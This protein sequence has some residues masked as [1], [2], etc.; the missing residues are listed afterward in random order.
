MFGLDV[1]PEIMLQYALPAAGAVFIFAIGIL[2][3]KWAGQ[4]VHTSLGRI[5]MEPPIRLLLVR[6]TRD[7]VVLLICWWS[8]NN[9][10]FRSFLFS[11]V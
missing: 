6:V 7:I 10:E 8:F 5:D 4:D 9:L 11:L 2:L 1:S 3:A